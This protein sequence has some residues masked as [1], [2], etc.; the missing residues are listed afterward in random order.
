MHEMALM[1]ERL[2]SGRQKL[3][4]E[5][6]VSLYCYIQ[7]LITIALLHFLSL[8][9]FLQ[10][11]SQSSEIESLFEENSTLS[12]SYQD[13]LQVARQWEN[14]VCATAMK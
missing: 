10:I 12:S 3:L 5:V 6:I 9:L 7:L 14:Q 4:M 1:V 13:A 8:F 11:D 2:E